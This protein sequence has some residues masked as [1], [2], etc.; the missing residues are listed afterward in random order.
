MKDQKFK[1]GLN[2]RLSFQIGLHVKDLALLEQFKLYFGSGCITKHGSKVLFRVQSSK[3]LASV[4]EHFQK[5]SLKTEKAADFILFE[6][7]FRLFLNKE[8]LDKEGLE[9]IVAIK[10]S[11]NL[12]LSDALKL[13]FPDVPALERPK[14][15]DK[16]IS[17]PQGVAGFTT[18]E[19][20]FS[21]YIHKFK[22]TPWIMPTSGST[23]Y[24]TSV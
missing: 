23:S 24:K 16:K 10:A 15:V 3:G 18:G 7:A 22:S 13:A 1:T 2:V 9:K 11:I 4:I 6:K 12:G 20:C 5:F 19:G 21:V 14:V 8:H 17:E